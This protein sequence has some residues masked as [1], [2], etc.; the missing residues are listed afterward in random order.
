[1]EYAIG[2]AVQ[3]PSYPFALLPISAFLFRR[4]SVL[5]RQ[6]MSS[7]PSEFNGGYKTKDLKVS[8]TAAD[9]RKCTEFPGKIRKGIGS[10]T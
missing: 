2:L 9:K 4:F 10:S 1:V 3:K 7:E 6:N 8:A 5:I